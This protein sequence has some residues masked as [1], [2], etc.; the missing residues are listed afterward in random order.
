V[1]N[2]GSISAG[3]LAAL[4]AVVAL[5]PASATASVAGKQSRGDAASTEL[6][7][8]H[9][10]R[11]ALRFWTPA[12][13]RAARPLDA[14]KAAGGGLAETSAAEAD[15]AGGGLLGGAERAVADFA[16]VADPAA[17]GFR[18]NGAIF[19][20]LPHGEG[21][22]R[23]SGTSVDAPNMSVV[24]TAAH[25][26]NDGGFDKW[27]DR[28]WIF[29]PG[30]HDG[31]RPFGVFVAKWL[32]VTRPWIEGGSENGDVGAAVVSRNERGQR[33]GA[34]VG[35]YGIA[36]N[37]PPRQVFDV[38]GYPAAPPF[39]G[40]SQRICTSKPFLGHDFASFLWLGPLNM[41][42]DCPLTGGASGGGWT[43]RG[44]VLNGVTDYG[45]SDDA[46]TTFGPYFGRAVGALYRQGARVR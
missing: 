15:G 31:V 44:D 17:P 21:L 7:A 24:F 19:V 27:F 37:L 30:Y 45:Y 11:Q 32:G 4:V 2:R 8:A 12:R 43:I 9:S 28:D 40:A 14:P 25:C 35:G 13:M 18:E 41:A 34:A 33:L 23:C 3:W 20:N 10:A 6:P 42:V 26:V 29:V 16:E 36:W 38:H 22:A 39:D 1:S 5:L 46:R